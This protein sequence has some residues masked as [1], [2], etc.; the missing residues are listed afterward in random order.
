MNQSSPQ[1]VE[2]YLRDRA[3]SRGRDFEP[4]DPV[5]TLCEDSFDAVALVVSLEELGLALPDE[6]LSN[7]T[8]SVSTVVQLVKEGPT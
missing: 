4:S 3:A 8:L 1:L 2:Q 7:P 6:A 5:W